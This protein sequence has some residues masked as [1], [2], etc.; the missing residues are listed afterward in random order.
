MRSRLR[1]FVLVGL[2]ATAL[3]IGVLLAIANR[4]GDGLEWAANIIA[5]ATASVFAYFGN[6]LFTF[7]ADREARW[8]R[9]PALFFAT[10][11]FAAALDTVVLYVGLGV[12]DRLLLAKIPAVAAG[13]VLRWGVYRW[14][15]FGRVRRELALRVDRPPSP[16]HFRLSVVVPAF[17]EADRI[18]DSI[19]ALR[20]ALV[21]E[22][23]D[24]ELQILIVDDGSTDDTA[25]A[26]RNA[27]ADVL[28]QPE[29]RGKGAAVRAGVIAAEGRTVVFT[30]ADLAY[31][32]A[33]VLDIMREVESGWDVVVGSR[34]H[35][36]T[37]TLVKARWFRELGGRF[38]NRLTHL[39][40]LGHFR[41]TQC[42][43]KGFRGDIGKVIFER[44]RIDGFAFDVEVFLIAEQDRLSLTEIPVSVENR[45]GST[46]RLLQ[47]TVHL[48]ID[49]VRL[50]RAAGWGWY[51][52]NP[53]QRDVLE[54]RTE[55]PTRD[56][57]QGGDRRAHTDG[58]KEP[59]PAPAPGS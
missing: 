29:N 9:Q 7:R 5:L 38:V 54:Q 11:T 42:G 59:S 31:P 27:G 26:A 46:V 22:V 19:Q 55:R 17:N 32:P 14:I 39:V 45:Q 58:S 12:T 37:T 8:V 18:A 6:R 1:R 3:D 47:D 15:L 4:I 2:V 57:R 16:G 13:A 10:A 40:L 21:S 52:P 53:T 43:I 51:A 23:G 56:R 33:H 24:D 25:S 50:R 34:R 44:C 35:E 36:D 20:G 48:F 30:D 49:L 28:I 41:D